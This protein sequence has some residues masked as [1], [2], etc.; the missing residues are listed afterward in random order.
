MQRV[1]FGVFD[2]SGGALFDLREGIK[3]CGVKHLHLEL[4]FGQVQLGQI[5]QIQPAH[6]LLRLVDAKQ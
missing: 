1:P 4:P 2:Q 5:G 3:I 6:G